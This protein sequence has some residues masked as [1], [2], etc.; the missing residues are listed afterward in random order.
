MKNKTCSKQ[1]VIHCRHEHQKLYKLHHATP[2]R[3]RKDQRHCQWPKSR[4][5]NK[6][7]LL[8]DSPPQMSKRDTGM[9]PRETG[10]YTPSQLTETLTNTLSWPQLYL[11][12]QL[13]P[14]PEKI[15]HRTTE[16]MQFP[17]FNCGQPLVLQM[18]IT[19]FSSHC[20]H[21]KEEKV[22]FSLTINHKKLYST[23]PGQH[24][25]TKRSNTDSNS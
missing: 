20:L 10:S 19:T 18:I 15:F 13:P 2:G 1:P 22:P 23:T 9:S 16:T 21:P 17:I 24:S 11:P 12:F 7:R 25:V 8:H 14:R 3:S 5:H 6:W 4:S